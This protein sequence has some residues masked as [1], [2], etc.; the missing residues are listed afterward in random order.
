MESQTAAEGVLS[1]EAAGR[2]AAESQADLF[3][4]LC[5]WS[6]IGYAVFDIAGHFVEI[7]A[8]GMLLLG[9]G[10]RLEWIQRSLGPLLDPSQSERVL[11]HLQEACAGEGKSLHQPCILYVLLPGEHGGPRRLQFFSRPHPAGGGRLCLTAFRDISAEAQRRESERQRQVV[12][13]ALSA[14]IAVASPEL[15]AGIGLNYLSACCDVSAEDPDGLA[16]RSAE[17]IGAVLSGELPHFQ[18]EYPCHSAQNQ[19]WF[20]MSVTPLGVDFGGVVVAH[21]DISARVRAEQE[22]RRRRE[23]V[24]HAS[25]LSSV[26]VLAASLVH[27]LSQPLAAAHLYAEAAVAL[28][29]KEPL[30]RTYLLSVMDDMRGQV[31]RATRIVEG[32]RRFMR[33]GEIKKEPSRLEERIREAVALVTPLARRKR[34][35][36]KLD[37]QTEPVIVRA[38]P[39]QIE[40]VLV[41]LLCNAIEAID[42]ASSPIRNIHVGV[43]TLVGAARVTVA[44]SGPGL[45]PD[46]VARIFGVLETKKESGMGMGLAISRTIV[47]AHGGKIWAESGP[48]T[49]AVLRFTLPLHDDGDTA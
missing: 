13:D 15:E 30:D 26:T 19:R 36:L 7:N 29:Q 46:W 24:A 8:A 47:E 1:G 22:S 41:N 31:D 3:T 49:G 6:P 37:L 14:Q 38:N 12:L 34:V 9:G 43:E 28:G 4:Q 16:H 39:L 21:M 5:D 40:Q 17:G 42:L 27:E 18:L 48:D 20:L 25:R 33:R 45:D 10:S 32:L 11:Q 23:E 44:D 35:R 2:P